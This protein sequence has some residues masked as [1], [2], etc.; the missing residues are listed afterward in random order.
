LNSRGTSATSVIIRSATPDDIPSI[1]QLERDSPGAAHWTEQ[2]YLRILNGNPAERVVLVAEQQKDVSSFSF[3][4]SRR[5]QQ[6]P[7]SIPNR[8][9]PE[10][11]NPKLHILGFIV[12]RA[13]GPEWEIE[14]I[15]V[16]AGAR[17]QHLATG[18]VNGILELAR[19]RGGVS[20]FLEVR[21]SNVAAQALYEKCGFVQTGRRSDYYLQA[22]EDAVLYRH[23]LLEVFSKPVEGV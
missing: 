23:Q 3:L 5:D 4:V 19:Q 22:A 15:A 16:S 12:A 14:N 2:E 7:P 10:T 8:S 20:V 1:L 17:R 6:L 9:K 11:G 13:I 18:L 21:E